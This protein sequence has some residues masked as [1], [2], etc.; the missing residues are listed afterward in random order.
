MINIG[1]TGET[2]RKQLPKTVFMHD[3]P[4]FVVG[5]KV[6]NSHKSMS[7]TVS[8]ELLA[9]GIKKDVGKKK[10]ET[11]QGILERKERESCSDF[12]EGDPQ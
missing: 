5:K 2:G 11:E 1:K 8:K 9:G 7:F 4:C 10:T 12:G 6:L 3:K